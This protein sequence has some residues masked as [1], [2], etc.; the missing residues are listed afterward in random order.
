MGEQ[1][2]SVDIGELNLSVRSFNCM[3]RAGWNTIGDILESIEN[4]QDLL[5]VRNLGKTSAEEI[6]RAL[7]DYQSSLLSNLNN[8]VIVIRNPSES[9]IVDTDADRD[10]SELNLSVRSY[11]CLRR[12]GYSNVEK[13]KEDIHNGL[14][15]RK[16]RNI[17]ARCEKEI[18][19]TLGCE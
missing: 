6:I 12:A 3:K 4:W 9:R 19:L 2:L 17:G 18:L 5:R 1:L 16:I 7:I 13:L 10:I 8:T 11:N 15:L 14:D